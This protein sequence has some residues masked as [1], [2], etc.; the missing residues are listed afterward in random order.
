MILCL[1]QNAYDARSPGHRARFE[2]MLQHGQWWHPGF[3]R[4]VNK[5]GSRLRLLF[6]FEWDPC[7]IWFFNT[8]WHVG[9]RPS[10]RLEPDP[11]YV[12]Y[13]IN[14]RRPDVVVATGVQAEQV[15]LEVW[16]GSLIVV[17][18]PTYRCLTNR[19]YRFAARTVLRMNSESRI[20]QRW[21]FR[22][23]RGWHRTEQL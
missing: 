12:R 22:Q 11:D 3:D 18:H 2:R 13:W 9:D 21:A 7:G 16:P 17:P 10:S 8:T 4:K 20:V 14:V 15:A 6:D 19:L 5:T 1:M 23:E